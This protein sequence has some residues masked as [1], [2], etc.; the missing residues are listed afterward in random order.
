MSSQF[1]I[2]LP[3]KSIEATKDFYLNTVGVPDGRSSLKWVDVN[4]YGHQI[5]FIESGDFKFNYMN[6][7]FEG[8]I[9]PSFHFGVILDQKEWNTQYEKFKK[10]D[11]LHIP[12]TNFLVNQTGEHQSFFLKDP[13][14][15]VI[16][17]KNYKVDNAIFEKK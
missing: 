6:Y 11:L 3:C 9:I 15:Y 7:N 13:N 1:H 10:M 17:F 12:K 2:S 5:T 14:E 8:A 4:L 16:E